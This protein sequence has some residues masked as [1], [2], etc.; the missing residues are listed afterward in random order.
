M[1]SRADAIIPANAFQ[2]CL[3]GD[4]L[5]SMQKWGEAEEHVIRS[6]SLDPEFM[7]AWDVWYMIYFKQKK[8]E[9]G[10]QVF[11]KQVGLHPKCAGPLFALGRIQAEMKAYDLALD[12]LKMASLFDSHHLGILI[13][14]ADIYVQTGKL[15]L[16]CNLLKKALQLSPENLQ[17]LNNYGACAFRLG[18]RESARSAF[19][20]IS[21]LDPKSTVG[22][23]GLAACANLSK[24]RGQTNGFLKKTQ[25]ASGET[26]KHSVET[27]EKVTV[28]H[29]ERIYHDL[30]DSKS[31]DLKRWEA[32][33]YISFVNKNYVIG[34]A[35]GLKCVEINPNK[36]DV[37][38]M[39]AAAQA[40]LQK[41]TDAIASYRTA[42][43]INP[44]S[45]ETW[46]FLAQLLFEQGRFTE[47][48]IAAG[49]FVELAPTNFESWRIWIGI[50][51]K[52][53]SF[54][55]AIDRINDAIAHF[56]KMALFWTLKG[57]CLFYDLHRSSEA[58]DTYNKATQVEPINTNA[59]SQL[60]RYYGN[61]GKLEMA[62]PAFR[63]A[64]EAD[65]HNADA[66]G[67]IGYSLFLEGKTDEAIDSYLKALK[68]N[69]KDENAWIN[70]VRAY[71]K[72]GNRL[73]AV[74]AANNL[75]SLN[76]QQA[77][78][79]RRDIGL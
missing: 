69:P 9:E 35:A 45:P 72:Q 27:A 74:E 55:K 23:Q 66:W 14:M 57:D 47:A 41:T 33:Q 21:E 5:C 60:G 6:V 18:D 26:S 58:F 13:S 28:E 65:P 49:R 67:G 40:G 50:T 77:S 19:K 76:P 78:Q 20:T 36:Q 51:R 62:L 30:V 37:W 2:S 52:K 48:E 75:E 32:V 11:T 43:N 25:E 61:S 39:L 8:L 22:W 70:I 73:K 79:L 63:R 15:D 29:L 1:F 7:P 42:L 24:N 3:R 31:V 56:P 38:I 44:K 54:L 4:N 53:G 12:S 34:E 68:C 17:V 16:A 46:F 71:S 10:I 64:V 59:W